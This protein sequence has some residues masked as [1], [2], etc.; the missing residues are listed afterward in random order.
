M[1]E[2]RFFFRS[3]KS[4]ERVKLKLKVEVNEFKL[5]LS[6]QGESCEDKVNVLSFTAL[7]CTAINV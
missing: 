5:H 7:V 6:R 1:L 3:T 4:V 2:A